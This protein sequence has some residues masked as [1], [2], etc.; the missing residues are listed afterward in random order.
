MKH[1]LF[2]ILV[3]TSLFSEDVILREV[4]EQECG[5][6]H[7]LYHPHSLP[8]GAWYRIMNNLSNHFGTDASLDYETSREIR[9]YLDEHSSDS[10]VIRREVIEIIRPIPQE[11]IRRELPTQRREIPRFEEERRVSP[12][13]VEQRE[14]H[15]RDDEN[16]K[17]RERDKNNLNYERREEH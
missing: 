6:C 8:R 10:R 7:A 13:M 1:I 3:V 11:Q 12:P 2:A 14:N 16:R 5:S 17:F 4:Y 9:I 15:H